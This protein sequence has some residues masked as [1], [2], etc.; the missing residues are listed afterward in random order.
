MK[1]KW[2]FPHRFRF[3]GWIIFIPSAILGLAAMYY[4]LDIISLIKELLFNAKPPTGTLTLEGFFSAG[5]QNMTDEIA[6]VGTIVGLLFIAFS[7]EKVED[8]MIGQLRLEALQWSVYANYIILA[9]AILTLY[10][11]AFFNVMVYNMFTVLVVFI[12]R[13]R[14]LIF[15][16]TILRYEKPA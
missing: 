8:E 7:R 5:S 10:D 4:E 1:T 14:W 15:G 16:T 12:I 6:G 9:I 2:L 3:I 11:N 13:F